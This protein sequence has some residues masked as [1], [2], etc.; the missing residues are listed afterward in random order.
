MSNNKGNLHSLPKKTSE[1]TRKPSTTVNSGHWTFKQDRAQN[2]NESRTKNQ[3]WKLR[4]P[5][6]FKLKWDFFH[7]VTKKRIS[8]TI[9]TMSQMSGKEICQIY[10]NGPLDQFSESSETGRI[11]KRDV[12][13]VLRS[14]ILIQ[15]RACSLDV[16]FASDI[17]IVVFLFASKKSLVK[18]R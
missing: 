7:A 18:R 17:P 12:E 2:A 1:T 14:N 4:Q 5:S 10:W 8:V 9:Q 6:I 11:R 15:V 13:H 3:L 16:R